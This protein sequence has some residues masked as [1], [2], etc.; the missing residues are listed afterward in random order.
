ML[1]G[2]DGLIDVFRD[3]GKDE[4]TLSKCRIPL[5][6]GVTVYIFETHNERKLLLRK[7]A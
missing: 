6:L 4:V 1:I 2:L 3:Q 5:R 7:L